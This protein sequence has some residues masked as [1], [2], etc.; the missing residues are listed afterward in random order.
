MLYI[1]KDAYSYVW[2]IGGTLKL[3][4]RA[5]YRSQKFSHLEHFAYPWAT[6]MIVT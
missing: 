4:V 1:L 6:I 2:K 3:L 5:V